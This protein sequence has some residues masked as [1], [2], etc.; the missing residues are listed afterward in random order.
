MNK[1]ACCHDLQPSQ[2]CTRL[3][4]G[5]RQPQACAAIE[6]EAT[7]QGADFEGIERAKSVAKS[8]R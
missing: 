5:V 1:T 6:D 7:A 8:R 3:T 4:V 2:P